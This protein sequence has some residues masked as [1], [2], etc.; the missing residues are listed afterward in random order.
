MLIRHVVYVVQVR[1]SN[2]LCWADSRRGEVAALLR[3]QPHRHHFARSRWSAAS[4]AS[5]SQDRDALGAAMWNLYVQELKL[6]GQH[7]IHKVVFFSIGRTRIDCCPVLPNLLLSFYLLDWF[8]IWHEGLSP[9]GTISS[10][11]RNVGVAGE[12]TTILASRC[13]APGMDMLA[14]ITIKYWQS[15][16]IQPSWFAMYGCCICSCAVCIFL[17]IERNRVGKT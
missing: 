4:R 13:S 11:R 17:S 7:G 9:K 8:S 16:S 6:L 5:D 2:S 12:D 15:H 10:E 3:R 14:G 1:G